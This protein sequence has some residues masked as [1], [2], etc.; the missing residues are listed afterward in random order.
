MLWRAAGAPS[1]YCQPHIYMKHFKFNDAWMCFEIWQWMSTYS[2]AATP[3]HFRI[4]E[5]I[6]HSWKQKPS[7][8]ILEP[9]KSP[10]HAIES[11]SHEVH[12]FEFDETLSVSRFTCKEKRRHVCT[13]SLQQ[14]RFLP[15]YIPPASPVHLC[16]IHYTFFLWFLRVKVQTTVSLVPAARKTL[17]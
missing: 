3:I 9:R 12:Y 11:A 17:M 16:Q 6:T 5:R 8:V 1:S 15:M 14:I 7:A 2:F 13:H 4:F 10:Q